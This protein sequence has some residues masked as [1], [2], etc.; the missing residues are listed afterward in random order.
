M[1]KAAETINQTG[2]AALAD[3]G[4]W[5]IICDF[6]G[7]ITP[8]DVTDAILKKFAPSRWE[9]IERDWLDGRI[10][11]RECMDRQVRLIS[12][13]RQELDDFLDEV[14][15]VPGFNEFIDYCRSREL[16]VLV[17]SDG[18]DYAIK[19]ILG[20]AGL[21]SVSVI[22]NRLCFDAAGYRLEFPYGSPGCG[23]GVCKC[24]VAAALGG[25]TLLIGDGKSDCCLAGKSAVVFARHGKR[26]HRHCRMENYPYLTWK[27][28]HEV[29]DRLESLLLQ[30]KADL[31]EAPSQNH[32]CAAS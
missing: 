15:V 28:F 6:D 10:S 24:A 30:T 25:K 9:E 2:Q 20:R 32:L 14:P 8:Y 16:G 21:A 27:D 29:R 18:L 4:E 13:S 23:S 22:A 26:L 12:A 7:T 1:L 31:V 17:L 5:Q 19:R 3:P 11:A